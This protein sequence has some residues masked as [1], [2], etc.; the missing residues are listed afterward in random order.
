MKKTSIKFESSTHSIYYLMHNYV[1]KNDTELYLLVLDMIELNILKS[2]KA[3]SEIRKMK[4]IE[5]RLNLCMIIINEKLRL[6]SAKEKFKLDVKTIKNYVKSIIDVDYDLY[7]N[8]CKQLRI[9]I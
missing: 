5:E 7:I 4:T 3:H 6:K 1:K 9:K 2:I 8:A